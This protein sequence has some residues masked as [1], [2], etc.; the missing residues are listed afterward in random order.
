MEGEPCGLGFRIVRPLVSP[1]AAERERWWEADVESVRKAVADRM[2]SGR[3]ASGLV[4][5][6][7]VRQ[8]EAVLQRR[9]N[10]DDSRKLPEQP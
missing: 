8:L 7:V 10:S 4:D 6:E 2:Q 3:A 5:E 1:D 9:E